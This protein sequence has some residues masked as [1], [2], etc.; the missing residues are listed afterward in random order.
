MLTNDDFEDL[1]ERNDVGNRDWD[2]QENCNFIYSLN[3]D[4]A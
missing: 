3:T 1:M 4:H 2:V